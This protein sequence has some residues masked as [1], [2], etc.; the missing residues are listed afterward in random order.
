MKKHEFPIAF[1]LLLVIYPRIY[2]QD[3]QITPPR[4]EFDGKKLQISYDVLNNKESDKLFVWVEIQKRTGEPLNAVSLSGDIGD[5]KGGKTKVITWIPE[6]D[7]LFLNEVVNVEIKAEKYIKSF[8]KGSM[9]LR[10]I[11]LPG[12]GQ[13]KISGGKPYW[14]MGVAAYGTLAG[15]LIYSSKY[16]KTYDQYTIEE[17]PKKRSDLYDQTQK[18]MNMASALLISSAAIW[19]ANLVWVMAI[20]NKYQPLKYG[21]ITLAPYADPLRGN[22]I[23]SMRVNF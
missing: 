21:R 22:T 11:A 20:P 18:Q 6:N 14:I 8:N 2:S 1:F 16:Q 5:I 3:F 7:S 13:T 19:T 12:L 23:L 15:G 17:D 9:V 10:S 4:L